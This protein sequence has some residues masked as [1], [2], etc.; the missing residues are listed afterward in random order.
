MS[1]LAGALF[2]AATALAQDPLAAPPRSLPEPFVNALRIANVPLNA[3][4]MVIQP[5]GPGAGQPGLPSMSL[6]ESMPMN[7]ASTMKLV[8][9]YAALNLLGPAYTWKTEAFAAGPLRRDVLEGDLALRGGGDP[10]W[11]V[12]HLWLLVHRIRGYGL[13]EIRGDLLLDKSAFLV[14]PTDPAA[15][16]GEGLRPYNAPPDAL[17]LNYKSVTFSFVPDADSKTARVIV[18]PPL[19]GLV[20]PPAVRAVDGPCGDWRGRL[21][22]DFAN[23]LA[24]QFRGSYPLACGERAW[25]VSVLDHTS[26]VGAVF[27]AL[28]EGSGGVWAGKVREAPVPADARRIAGHESAPLA[29]QIRDINKFS[30]NVMTRQLFLTLG[31]EMLPRQPGTTDRG[32]RAIRLW[33]ANRGLDMPELVLENGAGLSRIERVSPANLARLLTHAFASPLM[34]EFISSL[35]IVGVDGTMRNRT[36]AA[37]NAHIKTGLLADVRAV[38]GYVHALSG[39]RYVVVSIINHPNAR[40]GQPAHDALLEWVFRNG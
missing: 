39:R 28:W 32:A 27:R 33:L 9:T 21:Q 26:Y 16:D 22:G 31:A 10:A 36:G 24:P 19:S 18:T 4:G 14:P 1:V 13:R 2:A 40:D 15:F 23:P 30:N 3:V 37:G 35:P 34:P 29:E 5:L 6:N 11:V 12:E 25:H 17:L 38:A 7:P 8:T 20:L